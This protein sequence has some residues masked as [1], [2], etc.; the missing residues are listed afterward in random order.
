MKYDEKK[1]EW[2]V[3]IPK[4]T[5]G[6]LLSIKDADY[7]VGCP[8]CESGKR[9]NRVMYAA[10]VWSTIATTPISDERLSPLDKRPLRLMN[11]DEN[12]VVNERHAS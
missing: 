3:E 9:C 5:H 1:Q 6:R 8:L 11:H 12:Q 4:G 10:G 7:E 2:Y